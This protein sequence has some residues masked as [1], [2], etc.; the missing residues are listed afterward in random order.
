[1]INFSIW[2]GL[3]GLIILKK[4]K[5]KSIYHNCHFVIFLHLLTI[6]NNVIANFFDFI[7][8]TILS[9]NLFILNK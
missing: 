1:M 8:F 2:M 9:T 4:E 7:I 3:M 6:T 5:L